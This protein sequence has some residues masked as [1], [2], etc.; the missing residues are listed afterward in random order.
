MSFQKFLSLSA[1]SFKQL[2]IWEC[3]DSD[4]SSKGNQA[5]DCVQGHRELPSIKRFTL[6]MWILMSLSGLLVESR[7]V[8]RLKTSRS[9]LLQRS[10][11]VEPQ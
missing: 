1:I 9:D 4:V 10:L 2:D 6:L 8:T 3:L 11:I 7:V 5:A